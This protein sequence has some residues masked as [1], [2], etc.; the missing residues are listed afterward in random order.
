MLSSLKTCCVKLLYLSNGFI[1]V[2]NGESNC[3]RFPRR[4]A[5]D[6]FVHDDWLTQDNTTHDNTTGNNPTSQTWFLSSPSSSSSSSLFYFAAADK[7]VI[8]PKR[9]QGSRPV[10]LPLCRFVCPS[11]RRHSQSPRFTWRP[12]FFPP[13]LTAY[14][15]KNGKKKV[16][17]TDSANSL[18]VSECLRLSEGSN[19]LSDCLNGGGGLWLVPPLG[20]KK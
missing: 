19:K 15:S 2:G 4:V 14:F 20:D 10:V 3:S 6:S 8:K 13:P 16:W 12:N 5:V 9:L 1:S 18:I 11:A 7:Q 17:G